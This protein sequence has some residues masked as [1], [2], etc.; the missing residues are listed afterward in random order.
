VKFASFEYLGCHSFGIVVNNSVIPLDA[1]PDLRAYLPI[2]MAAKT[3]IP[4][5][6]IGIPLA[7]V[8]LL[9]PIPD[10]SNIFCVATNFHEPSRAGKPDPLY[11]LLFTRCSDAQTGH[12]RPILKPAQSEQFDYEGE[13]AVII[14][15]SGH[16][17]TRECAM[18]HVAGYS[19]FNDGSVRDWQKH[20]SQFTPG[21]NFFQS[22][23]FGPWMVTTDEI[24]DPTILT[25]ETRINSRVKQAIALDQMIFDIPWL[26][27]YISTFA[28]LRVGDVIVTGTPSGFG[29]SR[30]PK[31]FLTDGDVVEVEIAGLGTLRNVVR[32]DS[33]PRFSKFS[34]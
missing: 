24:P 25:L 11:P 29:A 2:L 17:I 21:K 30:E 4:A 22:A 1:A 31:E 23:G 7:D 12:N 8:V 10:P 5:G 14:G 6:A 34:Q 16:K 9:P 33:D 32:Q 19:C 18:N 20:S 27:S 15:K 26:I 3:A 28:P 13:L